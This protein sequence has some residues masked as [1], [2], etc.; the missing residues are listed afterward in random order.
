MND[1]LKDIVGGIKSKRGRVANIQFE[2]A[3]A[4]IFHL[5]SLRGDRTANVIT[6]VI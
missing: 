3:M 6:N 1:V 5:A 4:F 2:N